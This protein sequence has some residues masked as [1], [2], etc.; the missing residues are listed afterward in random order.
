MQSGIYIESKLYKLKERLA[1]WAR[2]Q[3]LSSSGRGAL[4]LA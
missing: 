3:K 2:N 4:F 1:V